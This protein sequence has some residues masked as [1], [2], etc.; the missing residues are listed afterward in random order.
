MSFPFWSIRT[1]CPYISPASCA[2]LEAC[3][4]PIR[5]SCHRHPPR[6]LRS[7]L[8]SGTKVCV[9]PLAPDV[10]VDLVALLFLRGFS[11]AACRECRHHSGARYGKFVRAFLVL[12]YLLTSYG[13]VV[14]SGKERATQQ[15]FNSLARALD[16]KNPPV[17]DST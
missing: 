17:S 2:P 14:V 10:L 4:F 13:L 7:T 15:E 6:A 3:L 1:R 9:F 16:I 12:T 8:Q 11:Y 5:P